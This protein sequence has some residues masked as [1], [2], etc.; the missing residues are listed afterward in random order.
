MSS[1]GSL[2]GLSVEVLRERLANL[3]VARANLIDIGKEV[4][5]LSKRAISSTLKKDRVS[6]DGILSE[7]SRVFRSLLENVSPYPELYYSNHF[8]SVA[9][10]YVEAIQFYSIVFDERL[11]DLEEI[12]VHPIPY[13]MGS[14]DLIGELKRGSLELLRKEEYAESFRYFEI[15]EE[16]Y[17]ELSDIDFADTIIPGFRRKL[18]IY[19]KV[20]DDWRLLLIDIESRI[21]LEK[22]CREAEKRFGSYAL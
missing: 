22:A 19:R 2:S 8:Y 21:K 20:I 6:A 17:E 5:H 18:D 15:A 13:I 11:K 10:E 16:I 4:T 9:A 14:I 7:L 1:G 12:G 3:E